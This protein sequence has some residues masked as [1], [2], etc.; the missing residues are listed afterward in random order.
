MARSTITLNT[1]PRLQIAWVA[2]LLVVAQVSAA[3]DNPH[4]NKATCQS[5][6]QDAEPVAGSVN[7]NEPNVDTLCETCHGDRGDARP[8]RHISGIEVGAL[9]IDA[10]LR[11]YLVDDKLACTTCHDAVFQCMRPNVYYRFEN[12]GF[13]RDRSSRDTGK[14]CMRCHENSDYEKLN[15]HAGVAGVPA[16]PTC[17]LCHES[18]PESNASGDIDLAFNMRG[19][20]NDMCL[21]CHNV[22]PHPSNML[23][24]KRKPGWVHFVTPSDDILANM[25][26][27]QERTGAELPLDPNTGE[28]YCATCHSPH[29]FKAGGEHGSQYQ[30]TKHKLRIDQSCQACHEK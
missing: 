21:G 20:L 4:W 14:F 18:V 19:D 28:I 5:C 22:S 7:L 10:E 16:K 17:A 2:A 11:Q 9:E 24:A 15:P 29:D 23:A 30:G 27:A 6:H 8:C 25:Q 13:L 3:Q 1:N 26:A 12:E